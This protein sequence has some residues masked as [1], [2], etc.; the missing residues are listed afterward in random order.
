MSNIT[1]NVNIHKKY[2]DDKTPTI[3]FSKGNV[4]ISTITSVEFI[5]KYPGC[6]QHANVPASLFMGLVNNN[7]L[8]DYNVDFYLNKHNSNNYMY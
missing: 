8:K 4:I 7:Q 2:G 3:V 6:T 5:N 1:I